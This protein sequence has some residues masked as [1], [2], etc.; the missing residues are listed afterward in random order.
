[1]NLTELEQRA[2]KE[3]MSDLQRRLELETKNLGSARFGLTKLQIRV[4]LFGEDT[5]S[6]KER[7]EF[8]KTYPEDIAKHETE[9]AR[10]QTQLDKLL[11]YGKE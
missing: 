7:E 2:I 4:K 11:A 5:L 10:L 8:T 9:I 6:D 1:M 3:L